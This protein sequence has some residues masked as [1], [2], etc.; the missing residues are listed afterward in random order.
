MFSVFKFKTWRFG[1]MIYF[2]FKG[3]V[4]GKT[5]WR[6]WNVINLAGTIFLL[7]IFTDEPSCFL[8][9]C[10]TVKMV[11]LYILVKLYNRLISGNTLITGR[12]SSVAIF[13]F[14][15]HR[16]KNGVKGTSNCHGNGHGSSS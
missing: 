11:V 9:L 2:L 3:V 8:E 15:T 7:P 13:L 10:P 4:F 16:M 12:I 5:V 6:C 1:Y 14:S